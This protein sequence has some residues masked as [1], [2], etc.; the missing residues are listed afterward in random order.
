[1]EKN[2]LKKFINEKHYFGEVVRQD[3][4]IGEGFV[5]I[6][7][8]VVPASSVWQLLLEIKASSVQLQTT[9]PF[10]RG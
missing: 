6:G 8:D 10:N 7:S 3:F 2:Q 1:M 5:K 4:I 9:T